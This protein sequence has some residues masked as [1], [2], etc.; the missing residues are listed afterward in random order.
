M[1]GERER[2]RREREY[3]L[4]IAQA[5][6]SD[7]LMIGPTAVGECVCIGDCL[8]YGEFL[9]VFD[10]INSSLIYLSLSL[11]HSL[12][13]PS[14]Y[15]LCVRFAESCTFPAQVTNIGLVLHTFDLFSHL[16]VVDQDVRF[17]PS[18]VL[19]L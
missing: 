10:V 12:S 17:A 2:E 9:I 19:L 15:L 11:S 7:S 14:Q 3:S 16:L 1:Y 13:H 5:S 6:L 8:C 18:A 4:E